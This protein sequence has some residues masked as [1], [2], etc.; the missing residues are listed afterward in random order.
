MDETAAIIGQRIRK[1][2]ETKGITQQDLEFAIDAASGHISR[3]E[4]GKTNPTKE[5]LNA[6]STALKL[7]LNEKLILLGLNVEAVSKD[8]IEEAK[9]SSQEYFSS[10]KNPAYLADDFEYIWNGNETMLRLIGA[11]SI[12]PSV[13]QYRKRMEG[14]HILQYLFDY[15]LGVRQRMPKE[16]WRDLAVDQCIYFMGFTN[17]SCRQGQPWVK[18]LID[19]L[20]K[21]ED[22]NEV[23]VEA[24]QKATKQSFE[25]R[26]IPVTYVLGNDW[27]EFYLSNTRINTCPRFIIVEYIPVAVYK[28]GT[29]KEVFSL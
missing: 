6:I 28:G 10:T 3:I 25:K 23:W 29:V 5:T 19:G 7:N 11:P 18:E 8:E 13:E 17:Y 9:V 2:R 12:G 4:S 21:T 14:T 24:S 1:F 27:Y 26:K 22:F 15:T 20:S 16:R